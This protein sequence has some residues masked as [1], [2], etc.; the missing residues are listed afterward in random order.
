M[1]RVVAVAHVKGGVGKTTTVVNLAA[2]LGEAGERSLVID[3]DPQGAATRSLGAQGDGELLRERLRWREGLETAALPSSAPGVDV[4]AGGTALLD[5]DRD[6]AGR[7]GPDSRLR[8]C[9]ERTEG[10]WDWFFLDCPAGLGILSVNAL[11]AAA[12][13]LV[14]TEGHPL[15]IEA[16][17]ELQR[18]IRDVRDAGL[19]PGLEVRGVLVCRAQAR[20]LAHRDAVGRLEEDY[21]NRV[22]PLIRENVALVKAPGLGRPAVL[23]SPRSPAAEDYR[24]A[25]RWVRTL[26]P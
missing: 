15:A 10:P 8:T 3:L 21:P 23:S 22:G 17:A 20:R 1:R 11:V 7:I 9:L 6:L 25:A 19:N 5:A 13:V 18:A 16:L 12:G 14:P 24:A 2:A 26:F 4:V